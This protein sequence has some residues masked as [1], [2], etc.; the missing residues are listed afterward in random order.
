MVTD[1]NMCSTSISLRLSIK[2]F[3]TNFNSKFK[4]AALK[5]SVEKCFHITFFYAVEHLKSPDYKISNDNA[6][7]EILGICTTF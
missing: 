6:K 7:L 5:K 4:L 3:L 2:Y 1:L